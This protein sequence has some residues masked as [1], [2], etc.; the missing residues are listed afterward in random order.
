MYIFIVSQYMK[1]RNI[2]NLQFYVPQIL[3]FCDCRHYLYVP[4]Q[5]PIRTIFLRF[6]TIP[7][8]TTLLGGSH[9]NVK[10]EVYC[11]S[12]CKNEVP[13]A[14]QNLFRPRANYKE[15]IKTQV[16]CI[17]HTSKQHRSHMHICKAQ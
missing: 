16:F 15:R 5:M 11:I 3:G 12:V 17:P 13:E 7:D 4:S 1:Q 6:Y 10:L 2:V 8:Y 14:Q 9:N